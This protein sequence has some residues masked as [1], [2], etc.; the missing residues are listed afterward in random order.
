MSRQ[1]PET[2]IKNGGGLEVAALESPQSR[3][4][5]RVE[6]KGRE[7]SV[8]GTI[9]GVRLWVVSYNID[10]LPSEDSDIEGPHGHLPQPPWD[11]CT[12]MDTGGLC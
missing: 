2:L 12:V 9:G 5:G 4:L 3:R 10:L 11:S 8:K 7:L 1:E 6:R